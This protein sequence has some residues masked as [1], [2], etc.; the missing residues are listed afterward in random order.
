MKYV[1]CAL[2]SASLTGSA[3]AALGG[4]ADLTPNTI[5]GGFHDTMVVH[6]SG[7]TTIGTFW[8]SWIRGYDFM[9]HSPTNVAAPSGWNM[10]VIGGP[11]PFDGY[12]I[13]YQANS[14]ANYLAPG[15]DLSGFAFD[16]VDSPAV[17]AGPVTLTNPPSPPRHVVTSFYYIGPAQGDPG[18]EFNVNIVPAPTSLA[19][20]ALG[21]LATTRR[22]RA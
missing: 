22:R 12:S 13:L 11:Y 17:L 18:F 4:S 14:P 2:A 6:N 10:Q 21:A 20:A 8:F 5:A 3:L 16:T 15:A 19:L 9:P 7:T 1:L